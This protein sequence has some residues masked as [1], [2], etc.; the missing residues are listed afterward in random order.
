MLERRLASSASQRSRFVRE[1]LKRRD[2]LSASPPLQTQVS[3]N[4]VP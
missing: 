2:A 1:E 3:S 4:S